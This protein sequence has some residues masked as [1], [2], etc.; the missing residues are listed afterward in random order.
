MG[1]GL[2]TGFAVVVVVVVVVTF[3][4]SLFVVTFVVLADFDLPLRVPA[5]SGDPHAINEMS[6]A[7]KIILLSIF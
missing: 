2:G 1:V 5:S 6:A 7:M 4:P 3:V